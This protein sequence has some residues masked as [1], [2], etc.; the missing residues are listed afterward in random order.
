MSRLDSQTKPA[1]DREDRVRDPKISRTSFFRDREALEALVHHAAPHLFARPVDAPIRIWF[2]DCATGEEAYSL[3]ILLLEQAAKLKVEPKIHIFATGL[4]ADAIKLARQGRYPLEIE[5]HVS[6]ERLGRF[7]T[8][9][10]ESYC[11]KREVRDLLVFAK[12]DVLKQPPFLHLDLISCRNLTISFDRK[13]QKEILAILHY[14]LKSGGYLYLGP[15]ANLDELAEFRAVDLKSGIF[16]PLASPARQRRAF[17]FP[18]LP[19]RAGSQEDEEALRAANEELALLH[20][21][22]QSSVAELKANEEKLQ[23]TA[24]EV[25]N[26]IAAT[27]FG[28][29]FLDAELRIK[30]FTPRLT[31]HFNVTGRDVGRFIADFTHRLKYNSLVEDA[32]PRCATRRRSSA[33]LKMTLAPFSWCACDLTTRPMTRLAES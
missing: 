17:E 5:A 26:L 24:D 29:L 15:A 31:D 23:S 20:E 30:R 16:Q 1:P 18:D 4:D 7:F 25:Q 33:R 11:I 22:L 6:S 14:T 21:D 9:D 8:R 27:D 12:H 32:K 13:L 19:V 2:L 10:G 3:A 28:V